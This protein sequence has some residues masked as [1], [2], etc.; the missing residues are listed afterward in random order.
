ML[1]M[2]YFVAI[3]FYIVLCYHLFGSKV[4]IYCLFVV[5]SVYRWIKVDFGSPSPIS[6]HCLML[7]LHYVPRGHS[8]HVLGHC[9]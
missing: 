7:R 9:G 2:F 3:H 8:N 4:E 6:L 1:T 5:L